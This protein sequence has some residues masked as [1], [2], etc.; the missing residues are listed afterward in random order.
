MPDVMPCP[1]AQVAQADPSRL[2]VVSAERTLTYEALDHCASGVAH[3][4]RQRGYTAGDRIAIYARNQWRYLAA[5]IGILRA[6]MVACPMSTRWPK[7]RVAQ[8]L[9]LIEAEGLLVDDAPFE[10]GGVDR[11]HLAG[12]VEASLVAQDDFVFDGAQDAT[13]VFTSGSSGMPKAA[14]HTWGNHYYSALGAATNMPL[15]VGDRWLLSLPL[16]H[17]GGLAIFFRCLLAGAT[18]VIPPP[19]YSLGAVMAAQRV[20]HVSLVATQLKRL[21]DEDAVA[22][23]QVKA[24]LLGGSA[25]PPALVEAAH[26]RGLPIHTTYGLTEMVSQVTTTPPQATRD[27]LASSGRVLP[28]R[29]LRIAEDGEI[30]VNGAVRFKGYVTGHVTEQPFDADGW[31]ATHDLG[32]LDADGYLH[33]T[34]R[35]DNQFISG[36]ENIQP[37]AIERALV[38]CPG[39]TRAVVVPVPDAEFGQR[40]VAFVQAVSAVAPAPAA[41]RL[42]LEATL[43]RFMIPQA[44]YDWPADAEAGMKVA[45]ANLIREAQRRAQEDNNAG[46]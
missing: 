33:V 21:L 12:V 32:G 15:H 46:D 28:H 23:D 2:A 3:A 26:R 9:A 14:L 41:L 44:F 1:L 6:G 16:Y 20:T 29:A 17:V 7:T 30:W 35:K 38:A 13:I 8:A 34:G 5:V 25:I 45:R 10:R 43:P 27:Q 4:L 37:E 11:H 42:A 36:G 40:P 19:A 18:V 31:F 22:L 39:V 24:L